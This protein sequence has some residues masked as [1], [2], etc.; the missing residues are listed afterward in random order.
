VSIDT[1]STERLV[2]ERMGRAHLDD[3]TALWADPKVGAHL[4]G[5]RTPEQVER[6]MDVNETHWDQHGFGF[7]AAHD[8][9]TG[10]F[11]GYVGLLR[12]RVDDEEEVEL[13]YG[14]LPHRWGQGLASEMA[15]AA[16]TTAD[17]ALG[18]PE[19][20]ALVLPSNA[21]SRRIIEKSGFRFER[22]VSH[23]GQTHML[24]RHRV[25]G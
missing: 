6:W 4:G 12:R 20:V 21:A 13:S 16:L 5:V 14:L 2:L 7:W 3:M 1:L 18:M 15:E 17:L 24:Y 9:E 11:L 25:P 23:A 8:R 10:E 19:V 22:E